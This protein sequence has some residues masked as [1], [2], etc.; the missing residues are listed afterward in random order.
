MVSAS[1]AWRIQPLLLIAQQGQRPFHGDALEADLV[2][3][4]QLAEPP[5]I[6]RDH[7]GRLGIPAGGLVFHEQDDGLPVGRCLDRA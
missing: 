1:P 7:V 5:E 4:A 2:A 6:R 3:R